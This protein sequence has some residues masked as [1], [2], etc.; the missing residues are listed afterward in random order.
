MCCDVKYIAPD[1]LLHKLCMYWAVENG[2]SLEYDVAVGQL[3]NGEEVD[4]TAVSTLVQPGGGTDIRTTTSTR[5]D[6]PSD[7]ERTRL[8][9]GERKMR[10]QLIGAEKVLGFIKQADSVLMKYIVAIQSNHT[11]GKCDNAVREVAHACTFADVQSR[12]NAN[13]H[14]GYHVK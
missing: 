6:M 11:H 2:S 10:K 14:A 5:D 4:V 8:R 7:A 1:K 13:N 12:E 3:G 9:L